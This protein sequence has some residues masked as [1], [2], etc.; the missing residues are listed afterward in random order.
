MDSR[1]YPRLWPKKPT[2]V[3]KNWD[4]KMG[5]F[6]ANKVRKKTEKEK[7]ASS[8][9]MSPILS[10]IAVKR[11]PQVDGRLDDTCWQEFPVPTRFISQD[12]KGLAD[13]PTYV[14]TVYDRN[15]LYLA[16]YCT[17]PYSDRIKIKGGQ[18]DGPVWRNDS[19]EIV[20]DADKEDKD[21]K[22]DYRFVTDVAGTKYDAK[23]TYSED[24]E[25][26]EKGWNSRWSVRTGLQQG[27]WTAEVAIPFSDLGIEK[28]EESDTLPLNFIRH[29]HA[30]EEE[31]LWCPGENLLGRLV[32]RRASFIGRVLPAEEGEFD[33]SKE[34]T[35]GMEVEN[36]TSA[37]EDVVAQ[38][39]LFSAEDGSKGSTTSKELTVKKKEKKPVTLNY[40]IGGAGTYYLA[41]SVT[42]K[43]EKT[44][45]YQ[46]LLPVG[47]TDSAFVQRWLLAG[48]FPN[49]GGR[50]ENSSGGPISPGCKGWDFDFLAGLGGEANIEPKKGMDC[51]TFIDRFQNEQPRWPGKW[52]ADK[53][54]WFVYQGKG[55]EIDFTKIFS[56]ATYVVG[57][58]A[59]YIISP[60]ERD[61]LVK[62]GSDDGYKLWFNHQIVASLHE[63]R[64]SAPDQNTHPVHL[65][66]GTNLL[67]LKVDQDFGGF[68]FYLRVSDLKGRAVSD[69]KFSP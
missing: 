63:H 26:E 7:K 59:C 3:Q 27:V 24:K 16:F 17:E 23:I 39:V 64:G 68:N 10:C 5:K 31:S 8:P 51:S 43:E 32:F 53:V 38:A 37:G 47:L 11:P 30:K 44:P 33:L 69:L 66:K 15:N 60:D 2:Y 46:I 19:L 6:V 22:V 61:V 52:K 36:R 41:L 20:I 65:Q 18:P 57:Y 34:N 40:K 14:Y 56:P 42:G 13:A 25:K 28:V 54:E 35:I 58:A 55:G 29:R 49:P 21:Q 48:P 67:L 45:Y 4:V 62:L 12:T 1:L 9:E 50:A